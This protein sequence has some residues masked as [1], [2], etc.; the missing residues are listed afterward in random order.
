[1]HVWRA[2]GGCVQV[3]AQV[4]VKQTCSFNPHR[5]NNTA[6]T[7]KSNDQR[8]K[9]RR[10]RVNPSPDINCFCIPLI[11]TFICYR[12]ASPLLPSSR[13][14]PPTPIPTPAPERASTPAIA[15]TLSVPSTH[16]LSYNAARKKTPSLPNANF[17][18]AQ[19]SPDPELPA[20]AAP[21]RISTPLDKKL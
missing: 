13:N 10:Q 8:K 15:P 3:K 6:S 11:Q 19:S 1:M 18:P 20:R 2:D 21:S 4:R 9:K 7:T 5:A 12:S 14:H 16:I 17:A